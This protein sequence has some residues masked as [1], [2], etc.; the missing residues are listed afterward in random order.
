MAVAGFNRGNRIVLADATQLACPL[1]VQ[2][3]VLANRPQ[4]AAQPLMLDTQLLILELG[5][6]GVG[7]RQGNGPVLAFT[8]QVQGGFSRQAGT[9]AIAVGPR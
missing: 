7:R 6:V 4:L 5:G 8:T 3:L 1:Q 9:K 2:M